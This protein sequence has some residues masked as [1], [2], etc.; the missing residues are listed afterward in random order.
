M[1]SRRRF[2]SS[3]I[4]AHP[5]NFDVQS[6][7]MGEIVKMWYQDLVIYLSIYTYIYITLSIIDIDFIYQFNLRLH[8]FSFFQCKKMF[9]KSSQ[10]FDWLGKWLII[11]LR[12]PRVVW[13]SNV[14]LVFNCRNIEFTTIK[15]IFFLYEFHIYANTIDVNPAHVYFVIAMSSLHG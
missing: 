1:R 8:H 4:I 5:V 12:R 10:V 7:T 11:D 9:F 15:N 13:R 14:G 3:S 2:G 6:D